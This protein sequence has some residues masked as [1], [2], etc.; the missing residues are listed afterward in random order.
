MTMAAFFWRRLEGLNLQDLSQASD[1]QIK[2]VTD[3]VWEIKRLLNG[4]IAGK[5]SDILADLN[6]VQGTKLSA[7][8]VGD[9][10][11]SIPRDVLLGAQQQWLPN[12]GSEIANGPMAAR[13]AQVD[14]KRQEVPAPAPAAEM[15]PDDK[16]ERA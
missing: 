5:A 9:L 16:P 7:S 1:T 14:S 6:I 15:S 10:T 11:A 13:D 8:L 4:L 2:A 3:M 12:L